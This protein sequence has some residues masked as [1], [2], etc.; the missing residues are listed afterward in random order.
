[1]EVECG[2]NVSNFTTSTTTWSPY[3]YYYYYYDWF[4]STWFDSTSISTT[5][6][7]SS[8]SCHYYSENFLMDDLA[9]GDYYLMF[10]KNGWAYGNYTI[11]VTCG[12]G[13]DFNGTDDTVGSIECG[14]TVT[15]TLSAYET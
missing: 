9:A 15:G 1:M 11:E 6:T 3:N 2:I 7:T 4:N 8:P 13:T 10:N 5:S 14:E 12:N